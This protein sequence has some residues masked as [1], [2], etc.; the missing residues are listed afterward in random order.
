VGRF[1]Q[2]DPVGNDDDFNLYAYTYN[3]P[4]NRTDPS[5]KCG[6]FIGACVG[7]I[8]GVV[9]ESYSQIKSGQ[10]NIGK[11]AG[12]AVS[13]AIVG[14]AVTMGA[15]ILSA[16]LVQAG[17]GTATVLTVQAA[18]GA[19]GAFV[20]TLPAAAANAAITGTPMPDS[21]QLLVQG[22]AAAA[23]AIVGVGTGAA[24]SAA[25][26]ALQKALGPGT[27]TVAEVVATE[28]SSAFA[29]QK[30]SGAMQDSAAKPQLRA[31]Q[32]CRQDSDGKSRC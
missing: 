9:L 24:M 7:A 20:G 8:V 25:K 29:E 15:G 13:G 10:L 18:G 4:M 22:T 23:G 6:V 11:L 19:A 27:A 3:D 28:G 1:L 5:G 17:A 12:A 14:Q 16:P 30:A 32:Q 31:P 26:P 21:G 2:T